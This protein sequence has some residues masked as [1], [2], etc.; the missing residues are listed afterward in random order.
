[1]SFTTPRL[2]VPAHMC[3]LMLMFPD[4]TGWAIANLSSSV[5][6]ARRLSI[7]P[8]CWHDTNKSSA[9]MAPPSSPLQQTLTAAPANMKAMGHRGG[10]LR[11]RTPIPRQR[12]SSS[13]RR[14]S[15]DRPPCLQEPI[16]R[17]PRMPPPDIGRASL[18]MGTRPTGHQG[19]LHRNSAAPTP[20]LPHPQSSA[21]PSRH[22]WRL[23]TRPAWGT[24]SL[25]PCRRRYTWSPRVSSCR[26]SNRPIY[27]N[28]TTHR[29]GRRRLRTAP[30]RPR[31]RTSRETRAPGRVGIGP[32][33]PNGLL[34]NG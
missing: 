18:N 34:A 10:D 8:T 32:R 29:H 1:M 28:C 20:T 26:V 15:L 11:S 16:S 21:R 6:V 12:C 22:R 2:L 19:T 31:H 30:I 33:R 23:P 4:A 14:G 17:L 9:C 27:Q 3:V 24:I 5:L 25:E 7:D 13:N